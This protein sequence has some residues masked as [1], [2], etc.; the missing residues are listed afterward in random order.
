MDKLCTDI[1][2]GKVSREE[3]ESLVRSLVHTYP[4]LVNQTVCE[5]KLSGTYAYVLNFHRVQVF[6]EDG[7]KSPHSFKVVKLGMSTESLTNRVV[8]QGRQYALKNAWVQPRI[9]GFDRKDKKNTL[10]MMKKTHVTS[11]QFADFVREC[12]KTFPDMVFVSPGLV[13]DESKLRDLY[14]TR[15]GL[16]KLDKA[17]LDRFFDGH[18]VKSAVVT[19]KGI[20][21]ANGGWKIWLT[22]REDSP[23]VSNYSTGPSEYFLMREQ[24]IKDCKTRFLRRKP[25]CKKKYT[26][27]YALPHKCI[28]HRSK[29]DKRPMVLVRPK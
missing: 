3:C 27:E 7:S 25:L 22:E 24:D 18:F 29:K 21:K 17:C 23:G 20:I 9:P 26:S 1:R 16:W 19:K 28:I 10:S 8:Y 12:H 2:C 14:G 13:A 4:E 11:D 15:I 6:L 5:N